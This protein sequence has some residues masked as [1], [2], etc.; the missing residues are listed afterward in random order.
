MKIKSILKTAVCVAV[1]STNAINAMA[2]DKA[3]GSGP[4]PYSDCGIGA[5]I[6]P[7]SN[8]GAAISNVIWDAGTTAVT[9]ATASP[10]TCQG[11]DVEAAA[12]ILES[13]DRLVEETASGEGEHLDTLLS[14]VNESGNAELVSGL[15]SKIAEIIGSDGYAEFN[16]VEKAQAYY[17]AMM[18]SKQN[19]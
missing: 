6:F 2:E 15:R 5:A 16:Q 19:S 10:E 4:N 7:N 13:Y 18:V 14:I 1:F 17:S 11:Q 9:S 12:F 3:P 8:V